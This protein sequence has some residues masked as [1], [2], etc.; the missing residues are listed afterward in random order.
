MGFMVWDLETLNLFEVWGFEFLGCL[1]GGMAG[2]CE[3][4]FVGNDKS[5]DG[6]MRLLPPLLQGLAK[7]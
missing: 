2:N 7:N 5:R 3:T 6:G 4:A 1:G